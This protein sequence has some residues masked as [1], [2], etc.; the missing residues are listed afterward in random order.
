MQFGQVHCFVQT[1]LCIIAFS[2][3]SEMTSYTEVHQRSHWAAIS[4]GVRGCAGLTFGSLAS[5]QHRCDMPRHCIQR[6]CDINTAYSMY[7][8]TSTP[9]MYAQLTACP[10]VKSFPLQFLAVA[11]LLMLLN[12]PLAKP[13]NCQDPKASP[14]HPCQ[15]HP[16]SPL[17]KLT[18][19][20]TQ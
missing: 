8:L 17:S 11:Y 15:H 19:A 18:S 1:S 2:E 4:S 3:L 9:L 14:E 13:V 7:S 10:F 16:S 5:T 20:G 12:Q 6:S